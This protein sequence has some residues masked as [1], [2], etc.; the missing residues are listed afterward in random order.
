[1]RAPVDLRG[2]D[3]GDSDAKPARSYDVA[4]RKAKL[5]CPL[6]R[7][8][9]TPWEKVEIAEETAAAPA[10]DAYGPRAAARAE[11][12]GPGPGGAAGSL[13]LCESRWPMARSR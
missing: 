12:L 1:M 7:V 2:L 11:G 9:A 3:N 10:E 5:P 4:V 8:G 6:Q 13:L